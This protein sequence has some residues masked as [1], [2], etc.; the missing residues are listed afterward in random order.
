[1]SM[2]STFIA[3]VFGRTWPQTTDGLV[4]VAT[5]LE[6]V[7]ALAVVQLGKLTLGPHPYQHVNGALEG[8]LA[9]LDWN[10]CGHVVA[11]GSEAAKRFIDEATPLRAL[12]AAM[13]ASARYDRQLSDD[14]PMLS[15]LALAA[16]WIV[17]HRAGGPTD[18]CLRW[19]LATRQVAL[20]ALGAD[21]DRLPERVRHNHRP[22]QRLALEPVDQWTLDG[23]VHLQLTAA[24]RVALE[25]SC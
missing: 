2:A 8:E 20:D 17:K 6:S 10:K 19:G 24:D 1:M 9:L 12:G 18:E 14:L 4:V 5:V 7:A 21:G 25:S 13:L 23:L 15:G 11:T 22:E 16:G 3:S